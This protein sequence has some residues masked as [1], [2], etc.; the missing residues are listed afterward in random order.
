MEESTAKKIAYDHARKS[1]H[2][3]DLIESYGSMTSEDGIHYVYPPRMRFVPQEQADAYCKFR[4]TWIAFFHVD[5]CL[6]ASTMHGYIEIYIDT[7]TG[8]IW[9]RQDKKPT[10]QVKANIRKEKRLA[11]RN[12]T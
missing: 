12:K 4:E 6:S 9:E 3:I 7:E 5:M 1:F 2:G 10:S 11:K 8:D